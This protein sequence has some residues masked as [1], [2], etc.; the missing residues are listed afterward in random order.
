[1]VLIATGRTSDAIAAT[2]ELLGFQYFIGS[3]YIKVDPLFDTLRNDPAFK[4]M[5]AGKIAR[6][7][8]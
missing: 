4:R 5:L 8:D 7:V 6:P 1:M 3:G 2:E